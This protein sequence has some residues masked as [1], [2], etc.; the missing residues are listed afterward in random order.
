MSP[1]RAT[2][3][4]AAWTA[5]IGVAAASVSLLLFALPPLLLNRPPA[6]SGNRPED[7]RLLAVSTIPP[8]S[9]SEWKKSAPT[10]PEPDSSADIM[11]S[12]K[13][14]PVTRAMDTVLN[15]PAA[16]P[17]VSMPSLSIPTLPACDFTTISSFS[18]MTG[19]EKECFH[20]DEVDR[21]P[22]G[23]ATLQPRYP[24]KARRLGMCGRV[25]VRFLVN[26]D[27]SVSAL[28]IIEACPEGIFEKAVERTVPRWRFQPAFKDGVPV[29]SWV[30]TTIEFDLT[31]S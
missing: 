22:V 27:G 13:F 14:L 9:M 31:A 2:A 7:A 29:N 17:A 12:R 8:A 26:S 19:S 20:M 16:D 24:N 30:V 23:I 10:D 11:E 3:L 21:I 5:L 25:K 28:S 15:P 1:F 18:G 6:A 4:K